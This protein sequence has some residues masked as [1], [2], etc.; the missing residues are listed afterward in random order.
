MK[1]N[2]NRVTLLNIISTLLLQ[3]IAFITTPLFTRLLGTT[4]FGTY[5]IF[6][7]WVLILTCLMGAGISSSIGTGLYK[8]K[9]NYIV[10]R[11][12][13]LLSS[14]FIC[15]LEILIIIL[16]SPFLSRVMGFSSG[17][18]LLVGITAFAHYIVNFAQMAFIYEKKAG[19]NFI[20]SVS[21]SII[22]VLFSVFLIYQVDSNSRYLGRIYGVASIYLLVAIIVWLLLYLKKPTLV[23]K[24][25]LIYGITVGFPIVFHSLSQQ[26]LGQSDRIMMQMFEI[27]TAEIGIYS[28]FYTLSSVLSTVLGALNNSWCPFYYDDVSE[29]KWEILDKKCKNYIEL[30]TVLSVGFLLLSREVSYIMADESYWSGLNIIPILALAV[31]FTFMYQFPVNF[32]FFYKKTK[33]IAIG[34]VGAGIFNIILNTVMIPMWGMYGAAIATALS[35]L[36]LFFAHYYIVTHMKDHPYHLKIK[37]FVPGIIG[38]GI[39]SILFYVLSPWWYMRWGLG[40][41]LGCFELF[42]IYKRKSIF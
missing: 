13:I 14:T 24:E 1:T 29:E 32:E 41:G 39:G 16:L 6:N 3:G 12:S 20:L 4:Q 8:F 15:L 40:L 11:N 33:I 38:M 10:F 18:V 17:L 37:A 2:A 22:S 42:R 9:N 26:I 35:Y 34:T 31:Y 28:M 27:A 7:S 21:L 30:F 25:Y 23:K 19:S 36:A 5:S